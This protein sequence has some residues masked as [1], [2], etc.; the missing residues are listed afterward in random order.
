[1]PVRFPLPRNNLQSGSQPVT[2]QHDRRARRGRPAVLLLGADSMLGQ[3][4]CRTLSTAGLTVTQAGT[5]YRRS[6]SRLAEIAD[7]AEMREVVAAHDL[8]CN[9]MPVTGRSRGRRGRHEQGML[10]WLGRALDAEPGTR[11]IQRSTAMLYRDGGNQWIT[12]AWPVRAT[13]LT[14]QAAAAE[15]AA[16]RHAAR[17]GSTVILRLGHLYG[18]GDHWTAS[19]MT[20]A[21]RG[22]QPLSWDEDA[23]FPTLHLDD[24][25][26]AIT[27]S[28]LVPEGIYNVADTGPLTIRQLHAE[29]ADLAGQPRLHPL[30]EPVRHADRELLSRSWK[31]D[32]GAFTRQTG[33]HPATAPT[34]AYGLRDLFG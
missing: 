14:A 6:R 25:A 31:L 5:G 11:L 1:M 28:M 13:A 30:Y 10:E 7:P 8:V 17:G 27:A 15:N 33:W 19:L 20:L 21:R 2:S 24:A 23:Y 18:P 26:H 4:V 12:E 22:W 34:A 32:A 29:L 3:A 16:A 9:L